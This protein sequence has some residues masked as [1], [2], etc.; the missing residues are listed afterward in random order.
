[1]A[2][3]VIYG[4]EVKKKLQK[5]VDT[6][7]NAVKVTLG[8]RGRNVV[9]DKGFGG[10]TITND[11][12]SIAKDIVLKDKFENMGAEIIKE[13][14]MKTN[15]LAGDG[16]TTATVLMQAL[17]NEGL[18]QTTMGVNSM[19]VR[20]GMEHASQDVVAALQGMATKIKSL[21]EIKQV[22]TISAESAELGE[23]IA[24]TI[25]KVG[26]DGVV[27]VEESQSFG[28]ETEFTEGMEFDKG[29]V[30]P[31]MVTN[32][33]RM[34]A[35]Y[36]NAHIL[37]T[38]EKIAGIQD[39]LP[40][41]EKI[42]Q[43]GK[44][45]LVIIADDVEGE[46][47]ATFVVN[48]LKGGFSVL[49]VKAPGYGDRKKEVLAD[50]AV[51]T[52]GQ[53]ISKD[54]GLELKNTELAQLGSADRV[55]STKDNTTIV[56][57]GGDKASITARV[58]ALKA[59]LEQTTSKFDK[60]KLEERIAKLSG[61]VAVI[62]VGAA[63]ETEMKYLKLKIEDAVNATKAAIEE[64][65]VPGGGTSL[66]RAA[67][68]VEKD[69]MNKKDLSREEMI[70]YNI[71]LKALEVPLRQIADNTGKHD[72]A[73]IV[74]KVRNAGGN[75]GYDAAKAEMVDDM[76]KA[77][78]IDPVK[79]GRAGVQHAVSAAA[80]LLTTEAAIADEPEDKPAMPDMSGMGGMGGMY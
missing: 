48:K 5:G 16:T 23:K 79:V 45:E 80:I 72:G 51:T 60:E 35:E 20:N 63:T 50:I 2:K 17:V 27:T 41:L 55:V 8:P 7:A 78:I 19:A 73:V 4:E 76:I 59:Q 1:M 70:G 56:G 10:P 13:V 31:Y 67:A 61:G 26:K 43:T 25:D 54:I 40:L 49:A 57:G 71:V 65:I 12:V 69:I 34:E 15:E 52:G 37:I 6:V 18:K 47:L 14:A 36:K 46:A 42:A 53:V 32:A 11:G 75:A 38:D 28:I 24:E 3:Q 64:G 9:L 68:I 30:S 62:R 29:Y 22:A 77:G 44:K 39:I 33:E 74:E 66:T 58:S 21:D